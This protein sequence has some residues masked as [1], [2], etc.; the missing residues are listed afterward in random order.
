[1]TMFLM[2]IWIDGL[3][4]WGLVELRIGILHQIIIIL[5]LIYVILF[6]ELSA[7]LTFLTILLVL[8]APAATQAIVRCASSISFC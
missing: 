6:P 8:Q 4:K 2:Y 1:M 3:Y 5:Q 7:V